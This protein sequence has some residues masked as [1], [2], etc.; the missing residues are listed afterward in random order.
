MNCETD[1]N[2]RVLSKKDKR[3]IVL[4]LVFM[5]LIAF[6]MFEFKIQ[7]YSPWSQM[8]NSIVLPIIILIFL[9]LWN[10]RKKIFTRL[11]NLKAKGYFI[12]IIVLFLMS[13][14]ISIP[15]YGFLSLA[16]RTLGHKTDYLLKGEIIK[17]DSTISINNGLTSF[18]Y[19]VR[20]KENSTDKEYEFEIYQD[21]YKKLKENSVFEKHLTKGS[22]G[23]I[24]LKE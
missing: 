12:L 8:L 11:N 9:I 15:F 16:N 13:A 5:A 20:V 1:K 23:F 3:N 17:L 10:F 22:L 19:S 6:T 18:H 2:K 24:Y 4:C 21:E 14:T 7:D